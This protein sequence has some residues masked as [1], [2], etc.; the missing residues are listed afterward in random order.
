MIRRTGSRRALT[1][2]VCAL[3][4]LSGC[5]DPDGQAAP[6]PTAPSSSPASTAPVTP[7]V[8]AK[9]PTKRPPKR[10]RAK[11][12]PKRPRP[13]HTRPHTSR[14]HSGDLLAPSGRHYRAGQFCPKAARGKTT[15]DDAGNLLV[16]RPYGKRN[17]LHW[18]RA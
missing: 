3:L 5:K 4:L 6:P 12:R 11:P 14:P 9:P 2:L 16:C 17:L 13:T 7:S 15:H 8:T 18:V 10:P 1:A